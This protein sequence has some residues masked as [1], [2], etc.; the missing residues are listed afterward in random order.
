MSVTL[1]T[2]MGMAE[3]DSAF[4]AVYPIDIQLGLNG[5]ESIEIKNQVLGGPCSIVSEDL[6]CTFPLTDLKGAS[7]SSS[8]VVENDDGDL[9]W[10]VTFDMS[11]TVPTITTL[12]MSILPVSSA[13]EEYIDRYNNQFRGRYMETEHD[14]GTQLNL[15]T[16]F[17]RLLNVD[18]GLNNNYSIDIN[19]YDPVG[20]SR[21]QGGK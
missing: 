4:A 19:V 11:E 13:Q 16:W 6:E 17:E 15:D 5:W 20:S 18:F 21:P 7:Y 8:M 14:Y 3:L 2:F 10:Q 12:K 9:V 1:I